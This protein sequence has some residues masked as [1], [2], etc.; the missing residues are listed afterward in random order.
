MTPRY[1]EAKN[2]TRLIYEE[3]L[4]FILGPSVAEEW[5]S[6]RNEWRSLL[7]I[8]TLKASIPNTQ[9]QKLTSKM[10]KLTKSDFNTYVVNKD[11]NIVIRRVER[12]EIII[13]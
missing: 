4:P 13:K 1:L 9:N 11:I 5:M 7:I 6:S 3:S 2:E 10:S 8:F 12:G